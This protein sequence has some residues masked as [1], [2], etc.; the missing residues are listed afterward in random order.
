M[1]LKLS[2]QAEDDIIAIAEQNLGQH[3]QDDIM[4][5]CLKLWI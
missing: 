2:V 1:E 3:R 4:W 5:S